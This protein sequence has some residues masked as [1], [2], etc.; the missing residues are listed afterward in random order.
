[1]TTT[2]SPLTGREIAQSWL[3]W[4]AEAQD[5]TGAYSHLEAIA[6]SQAADAVIA[7]RFVAASDTHTRTGLFTDESIETLR[8]Y[9]GYGTAVRYA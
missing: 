9:Q 4:G 2:D 7:V 6:A 5:L 3:I 1:M 8:V